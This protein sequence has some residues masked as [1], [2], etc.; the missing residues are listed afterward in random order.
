MPSC[1]YIRWCC[2]SVLLLSAHCHFVEQIVV[3]A[4]SKQL[5]ILKHVLCTAPTTVLPT[6]SSSANVVESK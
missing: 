3:D 4:V 5:A 1:L 2:I 6:A